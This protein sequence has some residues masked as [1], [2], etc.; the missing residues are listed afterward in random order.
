MSRE[1][2]YQ[3]TPETSFILAKVSNLGSG[4][5]GKGTHRQR[6]ISVP[7]REDH[8]HTGAAVI[9]S[10]LLGAVASLG[11]TRSPDNFQHL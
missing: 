7:P 1:K 8:E 6:E 4:E 2:L 9:Q 5:A 11:S 3:G 10:W